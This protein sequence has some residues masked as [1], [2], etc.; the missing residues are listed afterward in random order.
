[1]RGK[2]IT[3]LNMVFVILSI[4]LVVYNLLFAPQPNWK[5]V[6]RIMG[7]LLV[8]LLS[9]TSALH[10]QKASAEQIYKDAYGHLLGDIFADRPNQYRKLMK[11]IDLYNTDHLNSAIRRLSALLD[12]CETVKERAVVRYFV[13]CSAMDAGLYND[14]AEVLET[15][16]KENPALADAR[17]NLGV[18]YK[19]KGDLE[20]A[21]HTFEDV[22]VYDPK[23]AMAYVN[24]GQCYETQADWERSLYYAQAALKLDA[25]SLEAMAMGHLACERLGDSRNAERYHEMFIVNGGTEE[26]LK[27]WKGDFVVKTS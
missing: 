25:N 13:A 3:F 11:G 4:V 20:R 7:V 17:N 9:T 2:I 8:W 16:L 15:T 14:A 12:D 22:L 21:I 27:D 18:C 10:K 19:M 6:A 23:C 24:L 5:H 26:E 1:M